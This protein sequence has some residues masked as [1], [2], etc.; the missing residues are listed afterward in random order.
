MDEEDRYTRIT[1]RIPKDLH[2]QLTLA[3]DQTSKSLNAEIVGRLAES[4]RDKMAGSV[5]VSDIPLPELVER[6]EQLQAQMD[7][8]T[9]AERRRMLQLELSVRSSRESSLTSM[10]AQAQ[11][12]LDDLTEAL[13]DA[14]DADHLAKA[15][16]LATKI[17]EEKKN[18]AE[19]RQSVER[20]QQE[21]SERSQ[22]LREV[23]GSK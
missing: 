4:F 5:A 10:I 1:L 13:L 23:L 18:I 20:L 6:V 7:A 14:E 9:Q 11:H 15:K 3:A 19:L 17:E 21:Q 8:A 16:R 2:G 12:R 22:E